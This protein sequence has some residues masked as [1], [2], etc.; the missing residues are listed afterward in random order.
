MTVTMALLGLLPLIAFVL[1]DWYFDAKR[2]IYAAIVLSLLLVVVFYFI[3]GGFDS[4]L[5][6]EAGLIVMLGAIALKMNNA[7]FFKFQPVLV[8]V[9]LSLF[10]SYFQFFDQPYLV[11]LL[12]RV[13]HMMPQA[14]DA[15]ESPQMIALLSR[16]SGQMIGLFLFHAGLV[17]LA[18]VRGSNIVWVMT[19]IAIY[20]L[21]IVVVFLNALKMTR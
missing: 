21:M 7:L 1:I 15:L 3:D 20:P 14:K 10:L 18:A 16:V 4:T 5:A 9:C 11:K 12:P 19:R 8:G 13:A 17:A 6:I 2:G